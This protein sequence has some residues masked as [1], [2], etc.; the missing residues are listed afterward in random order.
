LTPLR[1]TGSESS[2]IV[3]PSSSS[4][5]APDLGR[6]DALAPLGHYHSIGYFRRPYGR[7]KNR[8]PFKRNQYRLS[9]LTGL[10]RKAPR[11]SDRRIH[12]NPSQNRRPSSTIFRTLI[13]S[14][15]IRLRSARMPSTISPCVNFFWLR[16]QA[17]AL[18]Q[19]CHAS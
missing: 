5:K 7:H 2:L 6:T 14:G 11:Q 3:N 4:T 1:A 13:L 9:I 16:Q 19:E 18:Q 15:F 10:I 17:P 8:P 12:H